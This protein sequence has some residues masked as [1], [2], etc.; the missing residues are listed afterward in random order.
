M[1]PRAC[2]GEG[3]EREIERERKRGVKTTI[4]EE[5]D[6]DA[7]RNELRCNCVDKGAPATRTVGEVERVVHPTRNALQHFSVRMANPHT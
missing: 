4:E 7:H 6:A 5:G 2:R 1:G 3:R